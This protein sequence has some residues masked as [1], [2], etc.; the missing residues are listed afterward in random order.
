MEIPMPWGEISLLRISGIVMGLGLLGFTLRQAQNRTRPRA[1]LL[2]M[3][4]FSIVL[5]LVASKPSLAD[6]VLRP[7]AFVDGS[8]FPRI[9]G[10]LVGSVLSL[11]MY[12]VYLTSSL[13]DSRRQLTSLIREQSIRQ[14]LSEVATKPTP[15]V[16][17]VIPAFNEEDSLAG[18][19]SHLPQTI[20]GLSAE[21]VVIVDGATDGTEEVAKKFGVPAVHL[22]NRGQPAAW[23]TGYEIA[24]RRNISMVATI[25]ADGQ[26]LP[27][28]L[29]S[30][31]KPII[32]GRAD[33]V[34]GSRVLGQF[35]VDNRIRGLGVKVFSWA[36]SRMI[37]QKI[38]DASNGFRG[39]RTSELN[40]LVLTEE[41]L[42]GAVELLMEAHKKGLR[43]VE[44]PVTVRP[45]TA[46]ESKKGETIPYG[47]GFGMAILR[48]WLK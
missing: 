39:I 30:V 19:L 11:F 31:L 10:L 20:L 7:F 25:D 21:P 37:R 33:L 17:I 40:R 26:L 47:F 6:A 48:N 23:V 9:V 44:V 34:N 15:D 46:G 14:Y 36:V 12:Q 27:E 13:A 29:S 1:S 24:R 5:I 38:T 18:V 43:I 2:F 22:V 32:D 35:Y 42:G 45:R 3:G 4:S 28:D 41:R 8:G 16:L